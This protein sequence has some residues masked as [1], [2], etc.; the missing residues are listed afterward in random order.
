M[1]RCSRQRSYWVR[2]RWHGWCKKSRPAHTHTL[3]HSPTSSP[4][5]QVHVLGADGAD[6][7]VNSPFWVECVAADL[8]APRTDLGG[9]GLAGAVAGVPAPFWIQPLD[10]FGN[11]CSVDEPQ[12]RAFEVLLYPQPIT[13]TGASG[14]V[15]GGAQP[16]ASPRAGVGRRGNKSALALA[17]LDG[18]TSGR[19][20]AGEGGILRGEYTATTAGPFVLSVRVSGKPLRGSPFLLCVAPAPTHT[21]S[22]LRLFAPAHGRLDDAEAGVASSFQIVA[23]DQ[24]GNVRKQG[25]DTFESFLIGPAAAPATVKD[26]SDGAY[27]VQYA[28]TV[29]GEYL[30]S[31]TRGGE[32]VKGSPFA[33]RVWPAATHAELCVVYGRGT[34][35]GEAGY[36]QSF[37]IEA[38]DA[39]NNPR[40]GGGDLFSAV[41]IG[42]VGKFD[43]IPPLQCDVTDQGEGT[44]EVA[45]TL[46]VCGV[47]RLQVRGARSPSPSLRSSPFNHPV[48]PGPRCP[49]RLGSEQGLQFALVALSLCFS[50][51]P[52]PAPSHSLASIPPSAKSM[53]GEGV[54]MGRPAVCWR[55]S[56][57]SP[58]TS[59]FT[60]PN[61]A[62]NIDPHCPPS[63]PG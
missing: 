42:P 8:D 57:P 25:G 52:T 10:A 16:A 61:I 38:R 13:D 4:L 19:V 56:H 49:F 53:D 51:S 23:R 36:R 50:P 55:L 20:W 21:P 41:L 29:A 39:H 27:S 59:K 31:L 17:G 35:A 33:L 11:L 6:S 45:Y 14:A 40:R 62:P 22:C 54:S 7:L 9:E 24:F 18:S 5:S 47:F 15:S 43:K 30:L 58:H 37:C 60:R 63:S 34:A 46:A 32:H 48:P 2:N 3:L 28:P 26:W 44:Y 12:L 1:C